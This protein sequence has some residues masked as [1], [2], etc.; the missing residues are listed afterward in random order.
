[1]AMFLLCVLGALFVTLQARHPIDLFQQKEHFE[2]DIVVD[3]NN[4]NAIFRT[5]RWT[6]G[7]IP[8]KFD[9]YWSEGYRRRV[10]VAMQEI[11]DHTCVRF[12]PHKDERDYIQ[13]IS[14]NG[15]YS[16][17]G[18]EG[19][20]Q[21]VSLKE[22]QWGSCWVHGTVVHELLHAVGLW[23]EQSRPDRD[24]YV[25]IHFDNIPKQLAYNFEK[26]SLNKSQTYDVPYNY[27]SVMHYDKTAF[28]KNGQ[29][30]IETKDKK[31][32]DRIGHRDHAVETDYAKIRAIYE[33]K[34]KYPAMP[35]P[36]LPPPTPAPPCVDQVSY[37]K[38]YKDSCHE[39]WTQSSCRKTCNHCNTN[40]TSTQTATARPEVCKDTVDY[41]HEYV[42]NCKL[43]GWME[44]YCRKTC[45][46]C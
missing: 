1:M 24:E 6:D 13:I 3:K 11:Q 46:F 20:R 23:H 30:T 41:C 5:T 19:G 7:I 32:Q 42:K 18:M 43:E 22:S 9:D 39:I 29:L 8:Y 45:K 31:M 27:L 16:S 38:E 40:G 33:C 44:D 35:N 4:R 36:T 17:V 34:G 12:V 21:Y 28:T 10:L 2:G 15:C 14:G 26:M 25:I 37:C